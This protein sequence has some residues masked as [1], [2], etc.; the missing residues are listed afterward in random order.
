MLRRLIAIAAKEIRQ[1]RRDR[2]TFG[3][4]VGLPVLQILLFGYAIELDVRDI[5]TAVA[6]HANTSTSRQVIAAA[7]ASQVIRIVRRASGPD[8][9]EALLDAGEIDAAIFIPHDFERRQ[10]DGDRPLGQLLINGSD[11]TIEGIVRQLS[12]MPLPGQDARPGLFESR[13]F[14][15]PERRTPVNIVPALIGVILHMTMVLFTAIAIVRERERGN[16]ELLITTPVRSSELM[17]GKIMPYVAIGLIQVTLIL[18]V[19]GWL[20]DVPL[21]GSLIDLYLAASLFI[22]AALALGL[23]VSTLATTQFQAMQLT[24]FTILPSILLSGFM[25]PFEGMPEFAQWIGEAI[26]LTHF[27]RLA[28]GIVVRG[29][30][31]S[32]LFGAIWPLLVFFAGFLVIATLRFNKRLD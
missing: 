3:M 28:R 7:E 30:G 8:E 11:P 27:I 5:Q 14:Y 20:F 10:I 1:L 16:L 4:I 6:D 21:R 29:A 2:L 15:N 24:L 9:L 22:L 17:L 18:I 32:E 23:T 19:S 25:F 26:P 31:L 12:S 13:T